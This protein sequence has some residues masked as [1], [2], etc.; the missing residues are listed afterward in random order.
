MKISQGNKHIQ[1]A[2]NRN[3]NKA[4][5]GFPYSICKKS[6]QQQISIIFT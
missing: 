5:A 1:N 6:L 2:V 4:E 3:L